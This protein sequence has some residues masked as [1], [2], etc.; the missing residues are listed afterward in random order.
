MSQRKED[1]KRGRVTPE[2]ARADIEKVFARFGTSNPGSEMD[3]A[4]QLVLQSLQILGNRVDKPEVLKILYIDN[5]SVSEMLPDL[6]MQTVKK[7]TEGRIAPD[8]ARDTLESAIP[9]YIKAFKELG[10]TPQHSWAV[11][12]KDRK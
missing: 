10:V 3:G 4:A 9:E 5:P 2:V 12:F 1:D 8:E 7:L 11:Y 6:A